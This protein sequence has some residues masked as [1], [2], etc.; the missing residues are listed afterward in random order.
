MDLSDDSKSII[1]R[2]RCLRLEQG[3][4]Q[5]KF[6]KAIGVSAGNVGSWEIYQSLPGTLALKSIA[7]KFGCSLDWLI[8]GKPSTTQQKEVIF[9]PDTRDMIEAVKL[10]MSDPDL[11]NRIWAKKQFQRTFPEYF[12]QALEEKKEHA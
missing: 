11:E 9:D 7:L 2:I 3:L 6:A 5:A 4:S 8:I 1:D 10:M 12:T